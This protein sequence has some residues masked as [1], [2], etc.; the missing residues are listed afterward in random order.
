MKNIIKTVSF[1]SLFAFTSLSSAAVI[2][3]GS[4]TADT[5]TD[6][7]F[8]S[9]L[10]R[11]YSQQ[12]TLNLNYADTL[13]AIAAGSGSIWEGW[14]IATSEIADDFAHSFLFNGSSSTST[15]GIND[16][17]GQTCG[18]LSNW[19]D[20]SFGSSW[21][22]SVDSFAF[23][24]TQAN[25][26][27][28]NAIFGNVHINASRVMMFDYSWDANLDLLAVGNH[29]VE[30]LLYNDNFQPGSSSNAVPEPSVVGLIAIGVAG[31]GFTARRKKLLVA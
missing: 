12:D 28:R 31:L 21:D 20:N 2:T 4:L 8:D 24:A 16:S 14:S 27:G 23:V 9:R 30:F 19:T 5:D 10:N 1:I 13:S 18:T 29:G 3:H 25:N 26:S 7:I 6:Y 22:D 17:F 11:H 15:C